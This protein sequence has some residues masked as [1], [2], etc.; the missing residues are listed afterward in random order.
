[1]AHLASDL[2]RSEAS[3]QSLKTKSLQS[4]AFSFCRLSFCA[5]GLFRARLP[6]LFRNIIHRFVAR[7]ARAANRGLHAALCFVW[8]E[9]FHLNLCAQGNLMSDVPPPETK[10]QKR[11]RQ[12]DESY[13]ELGHFI[14]AFEGMVDAARRTCLLILSAPN[15]KWQPLVNSALHHG[16]MTAKPILDIMMSLFGTNDE[17]PRDERCAQIR[18]IGIKNILESTRA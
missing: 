1:M 6:V 18:R 8:T 7:D 3:T 12:M 17:R 11:K 15:G 13:L 14:A 5:P 10:E 16:A 9:F 4:G 2:H